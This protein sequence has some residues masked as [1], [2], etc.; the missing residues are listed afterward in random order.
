VDDPEALVVALFP[1][2]VVHERPHAVAAHVDAVAHGA[3]DGGEMALQVGGPLGIL[4]MAVH[5]GRVVEG[6]A[7][8]GDVDRQRPVVAAQARQH[9]MQTVG[10]DLP[11][12]RGGRRLGLG[13]PGLQRQVAGRS[14]DALGVVVV[15]A[16]EVDRRADHREVAVADGFGRAVEPF[17]EAE[18]VGRIAPTQHR[19]QEPAIEMAVHAPGGVT[20]GL[21]RGR[22]VKRVLVERDPDLREIAELRAQRTQRQAVR[23]QQMMRRAQRRGPVADPRRLGP[24]GVAEEGDDP[25]LVVGDPL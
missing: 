7:V 3:G 19:V 16:E 12:H 25:R 15:D 11:A 14:G 17:V 24:V 2:E 22:G 4:D 10:A 23:Q 18:H 5:G 13:L 1:F 21:A 6:G 9:L 8:L 20:V